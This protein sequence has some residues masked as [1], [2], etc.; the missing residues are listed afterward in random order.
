MNQL[1][2]TYPTGGAICIGCGCTDQ[3]ACDGGCSWLA[4]YGDAGV[5][6]R[7]KQAIGPWDAGARLV[8]W[9]PDIPA[10]EALLVQV[11]GRAAREYRA[12]QALAAGVYYVLNEDSGTIRLVDECGQPAAVVE[13]TE[14]RITSTTDWEAYARAK[15]KQHVKAP[16]QKRGEQ[17][18]ATR[19]RAAAK[20]A[21]K[22]R[23][24]QRGRS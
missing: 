9:Y 21:R 14:L 12:G 16:D 24:A 20:A 22:A 3:C 13:G 2:V 15:P 1:P 23:R 4:R 6:S 19:R 10:G 8:G 11:G 18:K 5:C 17:L 7:C